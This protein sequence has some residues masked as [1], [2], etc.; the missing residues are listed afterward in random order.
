MYGNPQRIINAVSNQNRDRKEKQIINFGISV[1]MV[2][3]RTRCG[4]TGHLTLPSQ[5]KLEYARVTQ[6]CYQH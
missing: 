4:E 6:V 1:S 2:F 3:F 5:Q